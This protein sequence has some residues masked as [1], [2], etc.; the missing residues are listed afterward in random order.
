MIVEQKEWT[1]TLQKNNKE[2]SQKSDK[3]TASQ[4]WKAWLLGSYY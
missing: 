2:K 1:Y 4:A 3:K